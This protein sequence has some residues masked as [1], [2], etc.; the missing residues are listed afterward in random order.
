VTALRAW[1]LENWQLKLA[2]L[3]FAG[4]LW[5]FVAT[6]DLGEAVFTVPLDFVDQPPGLE[7]TSLAV[8]TVIVRVEGRRSMLRRLHEEDFRAEVSLRNARAGRFVAPMEDDNIV[9]PPGVR[10]VRVT[11]AEIRATL[12]T[13]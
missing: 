6:E 3:V 5:L 10:I 9:A 4:W 8:E 11:P 13:R 12:D 2:A 1:V 7:V